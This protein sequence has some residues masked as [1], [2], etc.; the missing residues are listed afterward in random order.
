MWTKKE[1]HVNL[2]LGIV[3]LVLLAGCT[4]SLQATET[5]LP[6]TATPD[7]LGLKCIHESGR[8]DYCYA[9]D[10]LAEDTA[11][12]EN[13]EQ[14]FCLYSDKYWCFI[15]IWKDEENVAQ[16]HPLTDTEASS[17]IAKFTSNPNT[18]I[19]CLQ[20]YNNGEVVSSSGSCE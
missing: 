18:G 7:T 3:A 17:L 6:E 2:L 11:Q 14:D 9:A 15:Y 13:A 19:E 12:L 16:S 1:Q 5:A 20:V 10:L 8:N 4:S